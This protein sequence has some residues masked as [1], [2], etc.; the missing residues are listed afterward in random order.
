VPKQP[1][2]ARRH[3]RPQR[4]SPWRFAAGLARR[5]TDLGPPSDV[6][7]VVMATGI[8]SI[9]LRD[10]GF[11]LID[12]GLGVL[13][14][15]IFALLV[16]R[17]M[18]AVV[19]G[20]TRAGAPDPDAATG[21]FTFVAA[22]TVLGARFEAHPAVL[23]TLAGAAAIGW[24]VLAPATVRAVWPQPVAVLRAH[25]HGGWLLA[26]VATAGLAITAADLAIIGRWPGWIVVS[27]AAWVLALLLY[28]VIAALIV[29]RA[30]AEPFDEQERQ[31]DSWILMGALAISAL[32]GDHL[33]A[34]ARARSSSGWLID[35]IRPGVTV[36][37][38]LASL[39]IPVLL[40]GQLRRIEARRGAALIT[41]SWWAA[42]FPLGMY[43][44]ATQ[45]TARQRN[46]PALG[47]ISRIFTWIAAGL[48]V[49]TA[50][51]RIRA[52]VAAV[53]GSPRP[54]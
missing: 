23:W 47:T 41:R 28:A 36:L 24:L 30:L 14:A 20:H 29:G 34:A 4:G 43:A 38:V 27:A 8:I 53:R 26:S 48:W 50:L 11:L 21:R 49:L 22:C 5:F 35:V 10:H 32:A 13:A 42:V 44:T 6:F 19:T 18:L 54:G 52:A 15:V 25:A 37:W 7:A 17:V 39:W 40:L 3:A 31:P 45:A 1:A 2:A 33:L 46:L 9:A 12:R 51:S 16:L